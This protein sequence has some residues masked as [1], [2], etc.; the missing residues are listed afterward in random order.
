MLLFAGIVLLSYRA[1]PQGKKQYLCTL[2]IAVV[3]FYVVNEVLCKHMLIDLVG[4]RMRP[5]LAHPALFHA[6]GKQILD[7]SFPSSHT[8]STVVVACLWIWRQAK[9]RPMAMLLVLAVGLSRIHNGMHYPSDGS[10]DNFILFIKRIWIHNQLF[11]IIHQ[12]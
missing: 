9:A 4:I 3:L 8:A 1:N 12:S 11:Q 5:Y 2:V 7:S 10:V 6:I